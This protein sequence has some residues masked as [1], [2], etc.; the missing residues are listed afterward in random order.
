M[1]FFGAI[2]F[3]LISIERNVVFGASV[4]LV[5]TE[6]CRSEP[7]TL[8][9]G[10]CVLDHSCIMPGVSIPEGALLGSF[11]VVPTGKRLEAMTVYTG[12]DNGTC[13]RLFQRALL[14]GETIQGERVVYDVVASDNS[15]CDN[16][17]LRLAPTALNARKLEAKALAR[18]S[19][20]FWLGL[21]NVWCAT[22][23]VLF[24]PLPE[25]VYWTTIII[26]FEICENLREHYM[27]EAVAV[28]L[29]GPIY[30]IVI[31]G[32]VLFIGLLKWLVIGKWTAGDRSYYSWFHFRW[33]AMMVVFA[34]LEDLLS[35]IQGTSLIVLFMRFMGAKIGE[36]VCYFGHGFEYDLLMIGDE[37]CVGKQCSMTAHT[38]ENMV[39]KMDAVDIDFGCNL[40]TDGLV[41]PGG[42]MGRSST[43]LEHSQV[44][45]GDTI[46]EGCYFGGLP[47]KLV[48]HYPEPFSS[49]AEVRPAPAN[50]E[51]RDYPLLGASS[52]YNSGHGSS[53]ELTLIR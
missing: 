21:F 44:L 41:M 46:D 28:L 1:D 53:I 10:A 50:L 20:P 11:T 15:S 30:V 43:L 48:H 37:A 49:A 47:G 13:V 31:F 51:L 39:M 42:V 52:K 35:K 19:S 4:L 36:R 2:E 25:V 29:I 38:V 17:S 22:S 33:T 40:L 12:C 14:P 26:D 8:R 23:A 9:Q 7:L 45:K 27:G 34:T 5:N 3:D 24:A 32:M 16:G 18:H 6:H